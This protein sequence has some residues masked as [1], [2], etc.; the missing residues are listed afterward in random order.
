MREGKD[1]IAK[2]PR[3]KVKVDECG[4]TFIQPPSRN[5]F[6]SDTIKILVISLHLSLPQDFVVCG[7]LSAKINVLYL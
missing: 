2:Q 5:C 6:F 7:F 3:D 1:G 4:W